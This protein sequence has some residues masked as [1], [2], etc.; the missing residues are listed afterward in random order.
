[1]SRASPWEHGKSVSTAYSSGMMTRSRDIPCSSNASRRILVSQDVQS[2]NSAKKSIDRDLQ[3]IDD[4]LIDNFSSAKSIPIWIKIFGLEE[5]E[6]DL[7]TGV[8]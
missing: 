8:N 7:H 3:S 1:M 6:D 4:V 2:I 5:I